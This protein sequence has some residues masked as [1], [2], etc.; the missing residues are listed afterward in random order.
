MRTVLSSTVYSA[1]RRQETGLG[2]R[3]PRPEPRLCGAQAEPQSHVCKTSSLDRVPAKSP[4]TH[5]VLSLTNRCPL[6]LP[7]AL[8]A[9]PGRRSQRDSAARHLSGLLMTLLPNRVQ[10]QRPYKATALSGTSNVV[11]SYFIEVMLC[12]GQLWPWAVAA[13]W[14]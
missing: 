9:L 8:T 5:N 10:D 1:H 11:M 12:K 3:V 2:G 6:E 7:W 14:K 4:A 13:L